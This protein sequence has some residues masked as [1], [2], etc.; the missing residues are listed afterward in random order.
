M[1]QQEPTYSTSEHGFGRWEKIESDP[2]ALIV[3]LPVILMLFVLFL[4]LLSMAG[5]RDSR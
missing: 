1:I 2:N 3:F 4:L 5:R